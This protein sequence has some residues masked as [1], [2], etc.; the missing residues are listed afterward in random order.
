MSCHLGQ[1]A[2]VCALGDGCLENVPDDGE[3]LRGVGGRGHG[4]DHVRQLVTRL[5]HR[6]LGA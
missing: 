6:A 1:F 2:G 5:G 3:P 4:G